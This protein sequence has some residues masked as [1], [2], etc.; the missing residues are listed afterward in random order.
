MTLLDI[1]KF[2]SEQISTEFRKAS[3]QGYGTPQEIADFREGYFKTFI[4]RF[5][6]LPH[7]VTKGQIIDSNNLRSA[8]I[9]CLVLNPSHPN[10]IDTSGKFSL[11]FADGVDV[12]IEVKPDLSR[13]DELER[14]LKQIQSIKKLRRA[15]TPLLLES[16]QDPK[17]LSI[18][19]Q[20]PSFIFSLK[21]KSDLVDTAKEI[22]SYYKANNVP[23]EEQFDFVV[24]LDKG[25]IYNCKHSN[26]CF[27]SPKKEG[28]YIEGWNEL[29]LAIFLLRAN[30][31]FHATAKMQESI[32]VPYL[33]DLKPQTYQ[34]LN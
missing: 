32:L 18:S 26:M 21:A 29:T 31:V 8:S 24:V 10:T 28:I 9:D 11:I 30:T 15:K 17:V 14:G 23:Q 25:I 22:S 2:E 1:L 27:S 13:T 4:E 33:K 5:F 20:I 7:K 19:K 16:K 3:L 34:V 6:P 12:A